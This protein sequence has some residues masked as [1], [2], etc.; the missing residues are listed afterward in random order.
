MKSVKRMRR[1]M[2]HIEFVWSYLVVKIAGFLGEVSHSD[3]HR[4]Y[5]ATILRKACEVTF[6]IYSEM[7]HLHVMR[8]KAVTEKNEVALFLHIK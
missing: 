5:E 2:R 4:L 6:P 1:Q 3:V 8:N 7:Q